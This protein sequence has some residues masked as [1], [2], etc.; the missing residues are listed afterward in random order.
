MLEHVNHFKLI[1]F[2]FNCP[3][4]LSTLIPISIK[5][6]VSLLTLLFKCAQVP[7]N[8]CIHIT[9]QIQVLHF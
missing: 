7:I 2:L 3:L 4:L 8:W 9:R 1:Y 6:F 5:F